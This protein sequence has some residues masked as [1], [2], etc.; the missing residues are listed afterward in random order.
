MS[1]NTTAKT[2][3]VTGANKGIGKEIARGLG[4][5]GY[6]VLIGSRDAKNGEAAVA[7]FKTQDIQA[8]TIPLEVT[9]E[10]SIHSAAK[11]VESK[12]GKLDVLVNNA[13]VFIDSA[14]PSETD[15]KIVR[16]TFD[17][18]FFAPIQMIQAFLPLLKKA[19]AARIVNV[20]STLGSLAQH[21]DPIRAFDEIQ[22]L[23]YNS[24]K[25]ALNAVTVHFAKELRG[26]PIKINSV[27]PGYCATDLNGHAGPRTPEQGAIAAI[28][29]ATLPADGPSGSYFDEDGVIAW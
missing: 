28:R 3:L 29:M 27:C 24:S 20:S 15:I 19:T 9:N 2:A 7:E 11:W 12:F 4:R 18:N 14:L 5:Q 22:A 8:F 13:G 21:S 6:T 23:G 25:T 1:S 10:A 17:A 26:T 16:K